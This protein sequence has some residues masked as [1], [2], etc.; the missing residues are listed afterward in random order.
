MFRIVTKSSPTLV[1]H[2]VMWCG[3][4]VVW[5]I[6]MINKTEWMTGRSSADHDWDSNQGKLLIQQHQHSREKAS[7]T[8]VGRWP[9]VVRSVSW[10]C[11]T[12]PVLL[13]LSTVTTV[14]RVR[15]SND[16]CC[17]GLRQ[18]Q[19]HSVLLSSSLQ[20][21]SQVGRHHQDIHQDFFTDNRTQQESW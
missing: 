18:Q 3:A 1:W 17:S 13:V 7:T 9:C 20:Q 16:W 19:Q 2:H 14:S 6:V 5:I 12:G 8:S 15:S 11:C 10:C 4:V 21:E